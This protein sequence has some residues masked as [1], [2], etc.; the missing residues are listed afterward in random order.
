MTSNNFHNKC[1]NK[2][3]TITLYKNEKSIFGG[4]SPISWST[5]GNWHASQDCFI[6]SLVN[7]YNSEPIKFPVKNMDQYSVLHGSI[8]GPIFGGGCDIGGNY[9]DFLNNYSYSS[10]PSS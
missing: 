2:G 10:F 7:I 5:D 4:F 9:S 3:P 8:Y 1:D 6:F